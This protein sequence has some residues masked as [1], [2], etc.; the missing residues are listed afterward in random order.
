MKVWSNPH[1]HPDVVVYTKMCRVLGLDESNDNIDTKVEINNN[2]YQN[3]LKY[4]ESNEQ[5]L[6]TLK[7]HPPIINSP[8]CSIGEELGLRNKEFVSKLANILF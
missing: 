2:A 1:H 8:Y 7:T 3:L 5:L 6:K 4:K